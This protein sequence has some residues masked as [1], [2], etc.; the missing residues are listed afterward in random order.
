MGLEVIVTGSAIYPLN[1]LKSEL[2]FVVLFKSR[3]LQS[4]DISYRS[5]LEAGPFRCFHADCSEQIFVAFALWGSFCRWHISTKNTP[6]PKLSRDIL[7]TLMTLEGR[8]RSP[9][10]S[11]QLEI[12]FLTPCSN[13]RSRQQVFIFAQYAWFSD[14]KARNPVLQ[15]TIIIIFLHWVELWNQNKAIINSSSWLP[16]CTVCSRMII[17]KQ[18]FSVDLD[19]LHWECVLGSSTPLLP[20]V[21]QLWVHSC[22]PMLHNS[23]TNLGDEA[24]LWSCLGDLGPGTISQP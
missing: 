3:T 12:C 18:L 8:E 2:W 11:A 20:R 6:A 4:P 5:T 17:F 15:N 1:Q 14:H 22:A 9:A 13:A 10:E 19:S 23:S 21:P 24:Q 16:P 7:D